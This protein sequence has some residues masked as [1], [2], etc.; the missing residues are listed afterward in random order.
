[1]AWAAILI[2][3]IML[4]LLSTAPDADLPNGLAIVKPLAFAAL[5]P[6]CWISCRSCRFRSGRLTIRY[7]AAPRPRL[8]TPCPVLS[9]SVWDSRREIFGYFGLISLT[10]LTMILTP[11]RERAETVLFA[12][13]T[14]TMFVAVELTLSG[15]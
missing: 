13:C 2:V 14:A 12:L 3:A 10:F 9:A 15:T 11:D 6:G 4:L 7:G 5:L 1:M 8:G